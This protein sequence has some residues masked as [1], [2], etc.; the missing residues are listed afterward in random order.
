MQTINKVLE[1]F[2]VRRFGVQ[3]YY[4]QREVILRQ[5]ELPFN[6]LLI[7]IIQHGIGPSFTLTSEWPTPRKENLRRSP[8]W[9][10]SKTN[11]LDFKNMGVKRVHA[12]GSPWLYVSNS[13]NLDCNKNE[14]ELEK[15]CLVFPS[16]KHF[17]YL[18]KTN[19]E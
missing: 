1:Q 9:V 3:F 19:L 6:A 4:G 8:L 5:A 17:M 2:L 15:Y 10:Y 12:I 13:L 16:H 14:F 18:E 7:G 11:L